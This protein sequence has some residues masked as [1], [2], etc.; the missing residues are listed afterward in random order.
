MDTLR[1]NRYKEN[2]ALFGWPERELSDNRDEID[3]QSPVATAVTPEDEE[4]IKLTDREKRSSRYEK[5]IN[6]PMKEAASSTND[7]DI[8]YI[9]TDALD[10]ALLNYIRVSLRVHGA[11]YQG[12][13]FRVIPAYSEFP[14]IHSQS[15][16]K[17]IFPPNPF[18]PCKR[19]HIKPVNYGEDYGNCYRSASGFADIKMW[20]PFYS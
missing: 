16:N 14:T 5:Y 13:P 7:D 6:T 9:Q 17:R 3:F 18:S 4:R 1:I 19:A 12:S 8:Q 15:E 20:S 2:K 10:R 11:A